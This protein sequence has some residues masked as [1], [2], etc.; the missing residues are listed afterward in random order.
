MENVFDEK[1]CRP[2]GRQTRGVRGILLKEGDTL[3]GMDVVPSVIDKKEKG[4]FRHLLV[5]TENGVGKRTDVY[6]YPSQKRGGI[7]IKVANLSP[8]NGKIAAAQVVSE[9][10][11]QVVLVS[12]KAITIK[13][14]LKNIPTLSRN[15][16]GVILMRFKSTDDKLSAMTIIDKN[17]S[18][19]D[20]EKS[21]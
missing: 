12:K 16:K 15:T 10:D 6:L 18:T 1:D 8:K 9:S 4:I 7:G 20:D 2:M 11:D 17:D 5:V 13:L 3:V 19:C 21:K 14:P